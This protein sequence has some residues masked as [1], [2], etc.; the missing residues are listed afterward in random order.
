MAVLL[1]SDLPETQ[2]DFGKF[3]DDY[4]VKNQD[5]AAV[6]IQVADELGQQGDEQALAS[7]GRLTRLKCFAASFAC[8]RAVIQAMT[9]VRT[10]RRPLRR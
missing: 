7:L 2:R 1:A 3:L 5:G 10:G 8:R 6:L 4:G 9:L